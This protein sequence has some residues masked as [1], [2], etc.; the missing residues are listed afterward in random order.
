MK[1]ILFRLFAVFL[2]LFLAL[3][4]FEVLLRFN[5]RLRYNFPSFK[6]EKN[7]KT[8]L[9]VFNDSHNDFTYRPSSLLGYELIPN[10]SSDINSYGMMDR[11]YKLKKEKNTFRILL[12]GDSIARHEHASVLLEGLLNTE[13]NLNAKY[14][15][16]IWN[17]GVGGYDIRKYAIYLRHKGLGYN[18]DMV[19]IYLCLNDFDLDTNIYYKSFG[20]TIGYRFEGPQVSKSYG[21]SPFL[22]ANSYLYRLLI[23][24]L[25]NCLSGDKKI[26]NKESLT[27]NGNYYLGLIKDICEKNKIPL[28][29]VIFPYLK[30]LDSY[31]QYQ[32]QQYKSICGTVKDLGVNYINLYESL[33]EGSLYELRQEKDDEIH[34]GSEGHALIS[35]EIYR[36]ILSKFFD[37]GRA[38]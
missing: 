2:G 10:S 21:V 7:H 16:E 6:E 33:P 3:L 24:D 18:P 14:K 5:G 30:S 1:K 22:I 35:K 29:V 23:L 20:K 38:S 15:F 4:F 31:T 37:K 36:F 25:E 8:M 9:S 19:V 26:K 27:E 13:A 34:P 32:L 12:L 11:D 28:F 17:A